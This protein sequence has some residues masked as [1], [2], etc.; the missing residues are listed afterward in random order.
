VKNAASVT[1]AAGI[2]SLLALASPAIA[3]TAASASPAQAGGAAASKCFITAV[4]A[5][6]RHLPCFRLQIGG[7]KDRSAARKCFTGARPAALG[8]VR[9]VRHLPCFRLRFPLQL[10]GG[11]DR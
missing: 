8:Q 11:N 6:A 3:A 1:A 2:V 10:G 4:G 9:V 5:S 7:G